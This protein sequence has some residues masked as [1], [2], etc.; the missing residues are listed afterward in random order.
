MLACWSRLISSS[1]DGCVP[2]LIPVSPILV[3]KSSPKKTLPKKTTL[4]DVIFAV[5]G[6]EPPISSEAIAPGDLNNTLEADQ[7]SPASLLNST[8]AQK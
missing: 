5:A 2:M 6:V 4:A 1:H 7:A 8:S 3:K